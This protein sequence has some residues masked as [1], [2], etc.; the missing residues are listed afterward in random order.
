MGVQEVFVETRQS[1]KNVEREEVE[2]DG[3]HAFGA[4]Y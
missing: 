1:L 2:E 4:F 3:A